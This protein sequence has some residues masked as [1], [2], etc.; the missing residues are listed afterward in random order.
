MATSRSLMQEILTDKQYIEGNAIVEISLQ[1]GMF[2]AGAAA[3]VLYG[4]IG[5]ERLLMLNAIAIFVSSLFLMSIQY[6]SIAKSSSHSS[7]LQDF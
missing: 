5:F 2:T 4:W 1:V 3:G 6:R 7:F